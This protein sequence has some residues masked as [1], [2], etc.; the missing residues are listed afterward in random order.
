MTACS[1]V[2]RDLAHIEYA[3]VHYWEC[4][5]I[6]LLGPGAE[7]TINASEVVTQERVVCYNGE[8]ESLGGEMK[9]IGV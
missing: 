5:V 3:I 7:R 8:S 4:F 9:V 6:R 1:V 2:R